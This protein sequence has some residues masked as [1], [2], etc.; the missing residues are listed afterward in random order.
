MLISSVL[1]IGQQQLQSLLQTKLAN[2]IAIRIMEKAIELDVQYFEDDEFYDKLQRA[3]RESS[4]RPYQIFWQM[5]TI[6][7]ECVTLVSVIAV[8]LYWNWWLGLLIVLAPLPSVAS[9]IFYGQ[10]SYK[11]ERERTQQ[12]RR[13]S[14]FQSLT[15]NA[16]SVK[17]IRLFRLGNHFLGQYKQLYNDF[18]KVDSDLLKRETRALVPCTILTNVA[19]AGAQIYAISITIATGHIGFLAGY[20]QA[21]AVLQHTVESLLWGVS[22]LYQNNLFVSSLFEFLDVAP[23][24]LTNGKRAVPERLQSGI[25]FRG[26]SFCYPDTAEMVLQDLNLFLKAGECVALVGHN[27]AGKTTLVKLLTRLYEPTAGAKFLDGVALE[28]YDTLGVRR[29]MCA[30]F[31]EFFG[32]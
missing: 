30:S 16:Q 31:P 29:R 27:G 2:V 23:S 13:L 11:I 20:M 10:Q 15:T 22:Q 12:R 4:Y 24:K 32:L 5:V 9:Q 26:V 7:S 3:N 8:L 6:G 19:S 21:I 28:G 18:Y 25:E 1:G 17:E 14:Y